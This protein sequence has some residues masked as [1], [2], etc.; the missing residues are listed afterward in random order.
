MR[1]QSQYHDEVNVSSPQCVVIAEVARGSV[2]GWHGGETLCRS[3]I[4]TSP[5]AA[6]SAAQRSAMGLRIPPA[7]VAS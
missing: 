1:A 3:E 7:I 2:G 5:K 4:A 6:N